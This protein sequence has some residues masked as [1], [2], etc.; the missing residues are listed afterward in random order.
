MVICIYRKAENDLYQATVLAQQRSKTFEED[1]ITQFQ[2]VWLNFENWSNQSRSSISTEWKYIREIFE[3][4]TPDQEWNHFANIPGTILDP[5]A[6]MKDWNSI[7]YPGQNDSMVTV[8][9]KV[10]INKKLYFLLLF[11]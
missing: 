8:V 10:C 2:R 11:L 1:I 3:S 5:K 6:P 9:K 7:S 4:L